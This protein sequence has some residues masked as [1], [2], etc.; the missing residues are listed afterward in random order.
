VSEK[1]AATVNGWGWPGL[2]RKAHYFVGGRS[3]CGS[4]LFFGALTAEQAVAEKPGPDDCARCH[5]LASK[6][7]RTE[8][9]K[10]EAMKSISFNEFLLRV[11]WSCTPDHLIRRG[12]VSADVG[13]PPPEDPVTNEEMQHVMYAAKMELL[14][15]LA[16]RKKKPRPKPP[17][18]GHGRK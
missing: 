18:R 12:E 9:A 15:Q 14:R 1:S 2:S 10:G 13:L 3:L 4:W 6:A 17:Q 7:A 5:K 16:R 11:S 8:A